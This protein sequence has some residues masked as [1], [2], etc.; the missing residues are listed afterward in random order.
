MDS[1]KDPAGIVGLWREMRQRW[2]RALPPAPAPLPR[3]AWGE[4]ELPSL[5]EL[6]ARLNRRAPAPPDC[7]SC[8]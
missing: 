3:P 4:A 2:Q 7:L 6:L 1:G 8:D 5:E